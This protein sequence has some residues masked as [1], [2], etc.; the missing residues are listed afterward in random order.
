[1][2]GSCPTSAKPLMTCLSCRI[3]TRQSFCLWK[4]NHTPV[5]GS[6]LWW[7]AS[8]SWVLHLPP[9]VCQQGQG[10]LPHLQG[11]SNPARAAASATWHWHNQTLSPTA[12]GYFSANSGCAF[13]HGKSSLGSLAQSVLRMQ[14]TVA[15]ASDATG[16]CETLQAAPA[17]CPGSLWQ[18]VAGRE[19]KY[20]QQSCVAKHWFCPGQTPQITAKE[21]IGHCLSNMRKQ[22]KQN[23][24]CSNWVPEMSVY[25]W[26]LKMYLPQKILWINEKNMC[27]TASTKQPRRIWYQISNL[28]KAK[29]HPWNGLSY[30]IFVTFLHRNTSTG[31]KYCLLQKSLCNLPQESKVSRLTPQSIFLQNFCWVHHPTILTA[32]ENSLDFTVSFLNNLT[33]NILLFV[34]LT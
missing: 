32:P 7:A 24:Q 2:W 27:Y 19:H 28:Q 31:E 6:S 23:V 30:N 15:S 3:W 14:T 17:L 29:I 20:H 34:N 8:L 11:P 26:N 9:G 18:A 1:M 12:A 16:R 5:A 4:P 13:C 25:Y 10:P 33:S 21:T 22:A